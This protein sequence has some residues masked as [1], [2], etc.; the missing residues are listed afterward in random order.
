MTETKTAAAVVESPEVTG[1]YHCPRC[2]NERCFIGIDR[3]AYP[4]AN[5][6]C[7]AYGKEGRECTCQA[8]ITQP[9]VVLHA[10]PML[11]I[12][13]QLHDGGYDSEIG[14]YERIECGEC[15]A[16]I[17]EKTGKWLLEGDGWDDEE[18][19]THTTQA[20]AERGLVDFLEN[21]YEAEKIKVTLN[22]K[23]CSVIITV[24]I[25]E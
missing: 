3:H 25:V 24:R 15:Q 21:E 8:T 19:N 4:G 2:S 22:G 17:W 20:E 16:V 10:S 6:L 12:D 14:S 18:A 1:D 9:F 5:C 7:G 23:P 11:D 13:Y